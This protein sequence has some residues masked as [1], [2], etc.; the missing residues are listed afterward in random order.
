MNLALYLLLNISICFIF[1]R[2]CKEIILQPCH[3]QHPRTIIQQVT[4]LR[5]TETTR[6]SLLC[7]NGLLNSF[8]DTDSSV[9]LRY[10]HAY[11]LISINE[12]L[13]AA[14]CSS[15]VRIHRNIVG[16]LSSSYDTGIYI[17]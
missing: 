12:T 14:S 2:K 17:T 5:P 15:C 13:V 10:H 3:R 7:P 6:T 1:A 16:L 4:Q 9:H 8:T 11:F